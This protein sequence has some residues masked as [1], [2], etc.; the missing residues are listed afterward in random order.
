MTS[1]EKRQD[2]PADSAESESAAESMRDKLET[3]RERLKNQTQ[4]SIERMQREQ[5]QQ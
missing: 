1:E 2:Q 5:Q 4:Q 3:A